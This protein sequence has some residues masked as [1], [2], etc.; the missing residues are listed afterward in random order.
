MINFG[1]YRFR[2]S[3]WQKPFDIAVVMTTIGRSTIFEAIQSI[4]QQEGVQR[5]QLLIGVDV[6]NGAIAPC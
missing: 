2:D 1:F 4:Y 6:P 3:D 5:I